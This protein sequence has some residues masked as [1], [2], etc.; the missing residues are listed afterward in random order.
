MNIREDIQKLLRELEVYRSHGLFAE[1]KEKCK[2][3]EKLIQQSDRLKN[4]EKLLDL[5]A[6]KLLELD[7]GARK[8]EQ[9]AASAQMPTA[10]PKL[11]QDTLRVS[12]KKDAEPATLDGATAALLCGQ[13]E[14]A[15]GEFNELIKK[16]ALR[17]VAAKNILRCHIELSAFDDAVMQYNLWFLSDQFTS[18]GLEK[19]YAYLKNALQQKGIDESLPKPEKMTGDTEDEFPQEDVLDILSLIIPLDNQSDEEEA[20][21]LDV[22]DQEGNMVSVII[23]QTN[24][25]LIDQLKIGSTLKEVQFSSPSVVF[26]DTC[27]VSA[28]K[29]IESGPDSGDYTFVMKIINI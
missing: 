16:D 15:L 11:S 26:K 14:K 13:F 3:L 7:S 18:A 17:V 19:I 10:E 22:R 2:T 25:A 1:A 20:V 28:I 4:K 6:K 21:K 9:A 5:V 29:Q 27:V 8:F 24:Q 23:P 12:R